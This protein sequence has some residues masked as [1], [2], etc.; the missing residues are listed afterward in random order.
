[1]ADYDYQDLPVH[2]VRQPDQGRVLFGVELDGA[3]VPFA[4][5]RIA[6]VTGLIEV[7]QEEAAAR[8]AAKPKPAPTPTPVAS[9]S[10]GTVPSDASA[11]QTLPSSP[12][13]PPSP[14]E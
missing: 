12:S 11:A 2:V 5:L 4:Q 13:S 7:A 3:Y 8:E 14:G 10:S 1:M 6:D 9:T